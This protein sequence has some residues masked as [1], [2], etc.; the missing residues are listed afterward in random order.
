MSA[1]LPAAVS[2]GPQAH[3]EIQG[4]RLAKPAIQPAPGP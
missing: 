3:V 1:V 2:G 4:V